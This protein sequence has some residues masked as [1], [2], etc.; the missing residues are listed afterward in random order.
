MVKKDFWFW[1]TDKVTNLHGVK[2]YPENESVIATLIISHGI[3]EHIGRYEEL[4]KFLTDR[5]IAVFGIDAVGHGKSKSEKKAPMYFGG[6]GSWKYLV[7][8]IMFLNKMVNKEYPDVPCFMLGFSMGSFVLR[9]AI[10]DSC[11]QETK[12]SGIILAGTGCISTPIA[13]MVKF[14]IA[15]ETKKCG[16]DDQISEK[17]NS[18]AF[19]NYNKHFQPTNTEFDWLCENQNALK[20]YINDEMTQ[21]F[22]TPGMFRELISAIDY[23]SKKS[24]VEKID[25]NLPV[26]FMSGKNDPVGSFEKGVKKVVKM[27]KKQ[28]SNVKLILYSETRHDVFHDNHASDAMHDLYD[29]IC[30]NI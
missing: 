13:T 15:K 11:L 25:K 9:T 12:V 22:I 21:K 2:F 4:A 20:D 14:L 24:T 3:G 19:G 10:V 30:E 29:W 8:D 28:V 6:V 7:N 1:S 5:R 23:T 26:L 16:G 17:V 18:L 27:F